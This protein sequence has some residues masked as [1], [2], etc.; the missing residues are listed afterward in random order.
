MK[1]LQSGIGALIQPPDINAFRQW[2]RTKSKALIDKRMTE[3]QAVSHF[4]HDGD[5]IG[6]ELN[7]TVR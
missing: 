5:Y 2:N 4:I 7:G 6:T 3:A 1:I